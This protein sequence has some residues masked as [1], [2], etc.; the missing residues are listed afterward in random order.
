MHLS[1]TQRR[2]DYWQRWRMNLCN[3]PVNKTTPETKEG[4][5]HCVEPPSHCRTNG[6]SWPPHPFQIIAWLTYFFFLVIGFGI[7][8]PLLPHHW[9]PA[10]YICTGVMF[11]CHLIVHLT[12]VSID[13]ADR[14]VRAKV[15]S[16]PVPMFD[17]NKHAHVI[18]NLHCY[19]CDVDVSPKSKHCSTCNKC[20]SNFD[21]H[22]KWLNNC[23]GGRNYWHFLNSVISALLGTLCVVLIA[24]YIFIEF[25]INPM[26]LRTNQHFEVLKNHTDVW[27]VFLPAAPIKTQAP[28][29]LALA[30]LVAT[31]G[32]LTLVLLGQLLSFHIYL[33]WNRLSTYEYIV[34]QRHRQ[35]ASDKNSEE[36]E[37]P[38]PKM[39]HLQ[40]AGFGGS[41]VY[42]NP[43]I[44]LDSSMESDRKESYEGK[45][46]YDV[47]HEA[48]S[49][50]SLSPKPQE[51]RPQRKPHKRRKK[52]KGFK[53]PAEVINDRSKERIKPQPVILVPQQEL[54][55][56][57][58]QSLLLPIP[59]FPLRAAEPASVPISASPIR[60]AGP[61]ADYHSESAESMD[62]IPIAQ[63]RLGSAA[64]T[65]YWQPT[66]HTSNNSLV[67][68]RQNLL[69]SKQTQNNWSEPPVSPKPSIRRKS[70]HRS[71]NI[72]QKFELVSKVP[73]VFVSH[74][75]GEPT[76]PKVRPSPRQLVGNSG[77]HKK[78]WSGKGQQGDQVFSVANAELLDLR[79]KTTA[80]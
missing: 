6:W 43:E 50:R 7:L 35:E 37:S 34:R 39:K 41:L 65:D 24:F 59:A 79:N 60:A 15:Q 12:A 74:S 45:S 42:T 72:N 9:I 67:S 47:K 53:V 31:L 68:S 1:H 28:A 49:E 13:P 21:H 57:P 78:K 32:L 17:R 27:F 69:L 44:K 58:S 61:P 33:M 36:P 5:A 48:D 52:K 30:A 66:H 16:G 26:M 29:I 10:G 14:N 73:T 46:S 40:D 56:P 4:R 19:L 25:F 62:E 70:F 51:E 64:V 77:Q 71:S 54:P 8:V 38:S 20:V 80:A 63:T 76:I 23:V 75:S 55:P 2:L 11:L 3:K 18:E 22:C